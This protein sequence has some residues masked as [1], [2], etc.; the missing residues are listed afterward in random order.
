MFSIFKRK[1]ANEEVVTDLKAFLSGTVIPM[2]EVEDEVFSSKAMGNGLAIKPKNNIVIAPCNGV[3]SLVMKDSKHAV[4]ITLNNGAELLIHV[5]IDTVNMNGE[6]FTLFVQEGDK[7][8]AGDK[9]LQFDMDLI[10]K[11]GFLTTTVLVLTNSDEFPNA[12]FITG[13]EAKINETAIVTF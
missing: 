5:G 10:Q 7:I 4:G 3:I 11:K 8:K 13:I 9:I 2:E 6:G 1:E 12:N